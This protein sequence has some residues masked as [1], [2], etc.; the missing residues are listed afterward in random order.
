MGRRTLKRVPLNFQGAL[1][2]V[3]EGGYI[4]PYLG[5]L[6]CN[7]CDGSGYNAATKQIAEDF[8]GLVGPC[9]GWSD[10]ITQDEVQALVDRNCLVYFTHT[11]KPGE[12]WKR[13]KD[14][15]IPTAKEVN[16][17]QHCAGLG[18]H[19]AINRY[20]LIET[21]AKRLGVFGSCPV[22]K[23]EGTLPHL[24]DAIQK[25][26]DAIIDRA[27]GR[28]KSGYTESHHIVPRCLGGGDG[29]SNRVNLTAE[30]HYVAHQLLV[31]IYPGAHG[32]AIAASS[33]LA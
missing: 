7:F 22:C 8:Y 2:E 14:G 15:Y 9:R 29:K 10:K 16:A 6:N 18:G 32:L 30:E 25:H 5:P 21:R 3:W 31:K 19:D 17:H 28:E 27:K 26:Y 24:G 4:N 33:C 11:C 12:G 20:I 1:G 13:R 23:D